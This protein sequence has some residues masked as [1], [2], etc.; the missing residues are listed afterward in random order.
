MT[1]ATEETPRGRAIVI[2]IGEF[3]EG[4]SVEGHG[5]GRT[6]LSHLVPAAD[7]LA[8]VLARYGYAVA[9]PSGEQLTSA[10]LWDVL[11]EEAPPGLQIVHLLSHGERGRTSGELKVI[12]SDGRASSVSAKITDIVDSDEAPVTLF[13]LD[14][15]RAGAAAELPWQIRG[16]DES[17]RAWVLAAA[18]REENAYDAKLTRAVA[19]ALNAAWDG[20]LGLDPSVEFIPWVLFR[21]RVISD[22]ERAGPTTLSQRVRSTLLDHTV[23]PPFFHNPRYSKGAAARSRV[24]AQLGIEATIV[25]LVDSA[26]DIEHFLDRAAGRDAPWGSDDARAARRRAL[27]SGRRHELESLSDWVTDP[28]SRGLRI[29]TGSPGSGKSAILGILVCAGHQALREPTRPVWSKASPD[30]GPVTNLA[31][32]HARGLS[33]AQV[34]LALADQLNLNVLP[35]APG[36]R[37]LTAAL[38]GAGVEATIVIDAVDEALDPRHLADSLLV[39]LADWSQSTSSPRVRLL[40]GTRSGPKW[41]M[42]SPLIAAAGSNLLDL[43]D[44]DPG[45]V[46]DDIKFYCMNWLPEEHGWTYL[47][48]SPLGN[49]IGTALAVVDEGRV[50]DGGFLI[51]SVYLS[52]LARGGPPQEG[53]LARMIDEIPRSLPA[54]LE[55]DLARAPAAHRFVLAAL[56]WAQGDGMPLSVIAP[57]AR[58]LAAD[59]ATLTDSEVV[60]ALDATRFYQRRSVDE[61]GSTLYGLFHQGLTDHLR[62]HP[63]GDET[64]AADPGTVYEGILDA[65]R[66]ATGEPVWAGAEPYLRRH[67]LAHALETDRALDLL[68]DPHFL[69]VADPVPTREA[70]NRANADVRTCDGA[71]LFRVAATRGGLTADERWDWLALVARQLGCRELG[72]AF[73]S[74]SATS[75]FRPFWAT[76][77]PVRG[78][79]HTLTGHTNSVTSVTTTTIDTTP[80][81]ITTSGDTAIVW[82]LTTGRARQRLPLPQSPAHLAIGPD[83]SLIVT[84]GRDIA[85]YRWLP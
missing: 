63:R 76:G 5:D 25:G 38:A 16:A 37:E 71:E 17:T 14:M 50:V 68:A 24:L 74:D 75:G 1:V 18:D 32:V 57:L 36:A 84:F 53:D 2:A 23:N 58:R 49:A 13:L 85:C 41:P 30:P 31:A 47:H 42:L 29:V 62:A 72:D 46:R 69:A 7:D 11:D 73:S 45:R 55:F 21:D 80:V 9:R 83:G 56:A 81:A 3:G 33:T 26:I 27:F 28:E 48:R 82:D 51:A 59:S 64:A 43:D 8:E 44:V 52:H 67:A 34:V 66:G 78:P 77:R 35:E 60:Q 70:L 54:V 61:D 22:V 79:R 4:D 65:R 6:W 12:G 39:P 20:T 19:A 10:H 40:V 15:C